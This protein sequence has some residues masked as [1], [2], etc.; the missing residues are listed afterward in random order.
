MVYAVRVIA[1][2]WRC[3][4]RQRSRRKACRMLSISHGSI[5]ALYAGGV[6][7][8]TIKIKTADRA[9]SSILPMRAPSRKGSSGEQ[10]SKGKAA[11][12]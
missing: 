7:G 6:R 4:T 8:E 2:A 9:Y 10:K 11:E 3:V 12:S 1:A 5:C